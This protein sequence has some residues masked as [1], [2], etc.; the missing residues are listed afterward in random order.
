MNTQKVRHLI[1]TQIT[2]HRTRIGVKLAGEEYV[3][4]CWQIGKLTQL[5]ILH[6]MPVKFGHSD[7][8]IVIEEATSGKKMVMG[9]AG[10]M[11]EI[12]PHPLYLAINSRRQRS[13]KVSQ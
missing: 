10:K 5:G 8:D 1:K 9:L 11:K 13:R 3:A 6:L 12:P 2:D 7:A 4:A